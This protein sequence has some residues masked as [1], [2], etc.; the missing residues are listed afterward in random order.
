VSLLKNPFRNVRVLLLTM[1]LLVGAAALLLGEQRASFLRPGLRLNAY[2]SGS[3]GSVAVVDLVRLRAVARVAIGPGLS[4]MR[5]HPTRAEV[6]GVSSQGGYVWVLS[7]R[8]NQVA[9]RIPVGAMPYALDFSADG[10]RVYTTASGSDA[11][12]AIDC[13]SRAIVAH[14]RTGHE[15]VLARASP[16]GKSVLVVNRR[17]A[18]LGIHDAATLALRWTVPVVA[19]PEDVA[20]MADSSLAFVLSRTE[21]RLSVVDLRRGV[22][23]TNLQ[24]A[25][26]PSEML[27][28][29]DGGEL[30]VISPESH[31]LQA[32]NTWTHEVG[33]YVVLGS[34]PTHGILLPDA[35]E[36][37][38]TDAEAGRVAPVDINNRRVGRPISAGQMPEALRFDSNDPDV[39]PNLLLVVNE[40]SGD[41]A[42]IGL[43][44]GSESLL[45][46][47]P[48]GPQPRDL[49][50]KLF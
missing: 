43:R 6:W 49:A 37:F 11:V 27:L 44:A 45:T 18:T 2:V 30:Y 28:K 10:A 16:D 36:M 35:S 22:L 14:G 29:P 46:M 9:A 21:P 5:E 26:K 3:D 47:I 4:G 24:L 23:L 50:V 48:V 25:G 41:L 42:V 1:V 8:V 19:L 31:G 15:P 33:D 20:V 40:G 39:K 38:V 7:A 34:A 12:M 13:Q 17:D 32:I